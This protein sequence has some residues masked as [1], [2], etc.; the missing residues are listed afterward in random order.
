METS[1]I[2]KATSTRVVLAAAVLAILPFVNALGAGFTFDDIPSIREN[3][4]VTQGIDPVGALA[5]PLFEVNY[6]PFTVLTFAVNEALAPGN[7]AWFHV[8]NVLLHA[9]V[10]VAV[11]ALARQLFKST[12][13]AAIAAALFAVHPIHTE[14]VTNLVG[15]AE[16]MAALFGLVALLTAVRTDAARGW[17]RVALQSLSWTSFS[18][19]VLSKESGLTILPLIPML[20]IACRGEPWGRGLWRELKS[21]DWVPYGLCAGLFVLLRSYV[22]GVATM[23]NVT[24]RLNN[25]L[26]FVPWPVRIASA[27][28]VLWDYFGLL[29]VPMVL[30]ADYSYNQVP[31]IR[32]WTDLR[33]LAGLG[34]VIA[35]A[36]LAARHRASAV[37]FAAA[38]PLVTLSLTAN[39][40][41]AIGTVKAE[42]LLYLP[43]I[44]W[45]LLVAYSLDHLLRNRRFRWATMAALCLMI[46]LFGARTWIRNWDWKDNAT[47]FRSMVVGAPW[48]A[49]ARFNWGAVLE[50]EEGNDDGALLQYRRALD[51]YPVPEAALAVGTIYER[52][53]RLGEALM[54]Y[55]KS[56][57][58]APGFW[59]AHEH[60]CSLLVRQKQFARAEVACRRGLRYTPGNEFLLARVGVS[61]VG[62]GTR[63]EGIDILRHCLTINPDDTALRAYLSQLEM[64]GPTGHVE[65]VARQ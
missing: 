65:R 40:V 56:L 5:S 42:R 7:A 35:G 58:F 8:V 28:G 46:A 54:W 41:V 23:P 53:G 44:G 30:A 6:R 57:E 18:L 11:L 14:A 26:I 2:D 34:I 4:A 3:P 25:V 37:R 48:S 33:L 22:I 31:V 55:E 32:S 16:L 12:Q 63:D 52:K 47:L 49:K 61:L 50:H 64:S 59:A 17:S 27:L 20:R 15:R 45:V 1:P 9:C 21:L 24:N 39:I 29:N 62:R 60:L 13:L 38:F 36:L 43:S 19:A 10:T 51:I